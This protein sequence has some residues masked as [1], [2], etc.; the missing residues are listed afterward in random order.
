MSVGSLSPRELG[1]RLAACHERRPDGWT[2]GKLLI[3]AI[4][5][6]S[7][8]GA[9]SIPGITDEALVRMLEEFL[10]GGETPK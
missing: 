1:E 7:L 4:D 6:R 3:R 9:V 2:F 10:D 5:A 8:G